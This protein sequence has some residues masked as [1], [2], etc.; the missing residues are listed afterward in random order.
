[1]RE[2]STPP[3][4]VIQ[5]MDVRFGSRKMQR[6]SL[7]VKQ[8]KLDFNHHV[9]VI[10]YIIIYRITR[11]ILHTG[12]HTRAHLHSTDFLSIDVNKAAIANYG[13]T[14]ESLSLFLLHAHPT[15]FAPFS[16]R[17]LKKLQNHRLKCIMRNIR[18]SSIRTCG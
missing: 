12:I 15:V 10:L 2:I 9:T 14:T 13:S 17:V 11:E 6:L 5:I 3:Y 8:R 18:T 4:L 1:M 16:W 7:R